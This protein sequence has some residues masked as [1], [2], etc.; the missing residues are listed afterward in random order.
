MNYS[1]SHRIQKVKT[2]PTIAISKLAGELKAAGKDIISLSVGE[3]DFDTPEAIKLAAIK[4]IEAGFTKYTAVD[5]IP[6]LK[7]A[8]INKLKRDNGLTYQP[9]QIIVANGVKHALY[10]FLQV[11]VE[12]GNEVIIPAPYWVS[13][14]DMVLLADATPVYI[15]TQV[16]QNFKITAAQLEQAITANTKVLILNSPNNPSGKVYTKQ[17]LAQLAEVLR[18]H[19]KVLIATDDM[20]EHIIWSPEPFANIV[21]AAPDLYDRTI[22]FNGVSKAYAMTGW[23]I[24]YAAGPEP[25][26]AAMLKIQSQNASNAN[27]IAQVA[28][29]AALDGDQTP[30]K[31]MNEV[32]KQRHDFVYD[33]LKKM[34]GISCKPAEGS[35]YILPNI[36][37]AMQ[38]LGL[39]ND[40]EFSQKLLE[41]GV[42]VVPGSAFGADDCIRISIATSMENLEKALERLK[43]LLTSHATA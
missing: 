26:I 21:N 5:G 10:N 32:F 2:S 16:D 22:I 3:P 31:K 37:K 9:K 38:N 15:K 25:I 35:F 4:A 7:N 24:G 40:I 13:Y 36:K 33:Q 28:A 1:L 41:K 20:Y 27:S 11:V 14:P 42:A 34:P 23:R 39:K 17:E 8:I 43:D 12:H 19:P 29:Q 18:R 6:A 30:V